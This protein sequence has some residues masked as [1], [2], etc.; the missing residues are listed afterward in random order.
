MAPVLRPPTFTTTDL[1]LIFNKAKVHFR[2]QDRKLH[3][4]AFLYALKLSAFAKFGGKPASDPADPLAAIAEQAILENLVSE[5]CATGIL[6][7]VV[8][9]AAADSVAPFSA[10]ATAP[11]D[12]PR[13]SKSTH[14]LHDSSTKIAS[15]SSKSASRANLGGAGGSASTRGSQ[16]NL[17]AA[18]AAS[19]AHATTSTRSRP[20]SRTGS[21]TNL[22]AGA[23]SKHELG[24]VE[25][26]PT[27]PSIPKGSVFDRL[28]NPSKYTGTHK[29]RFD[30]ATGK[31]R[32]LAGRSQENLGTKPLDKLVHR[33]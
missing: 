23:G 3:Y 21:R 33:S 25:F 22:A 8:R 12:A 17:M 29:E 31:G 4:D 26:T 1:D 32:G 20:A 11:C 27:V 28:T 19:A 30:P 9:S 2:R 10:A 13:R 18:T 15:S 14:Q 6:A 24:S 16:S 5:I 7:P